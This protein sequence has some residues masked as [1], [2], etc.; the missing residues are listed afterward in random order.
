MPK[1]QLSTE[2]AIEQ[3][4]EQ[5]ARY[6]LSYLQISQARMENFAPVVARLAGK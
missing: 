5:R 3:L 1:R 2:Q 6:G 4:L